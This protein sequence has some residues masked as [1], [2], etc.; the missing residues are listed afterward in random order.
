MVNVLLT[1]IFVTELHTAATALMNHVSTAIYRLIVH[2]VKLNVLQIVV[3]STHVS[4]AIR[5]TIVVII[6]TKT[7][8]FAAHALVN[9]R[10]FAAGTD[11]VLTRTS[12]AM[13]ITLVEMEA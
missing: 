5:T 3:A 1:R 12:S 7:N 13:G 9:R 8:R 2:P 10:M 4:S 6:L 11:N